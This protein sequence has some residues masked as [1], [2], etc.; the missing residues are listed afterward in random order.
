MGSL[1]PHKQPFLLMQEF[2]MQNA[3]MLNTYSLL[4]SDL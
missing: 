4:T 2:R 1:L 3:G